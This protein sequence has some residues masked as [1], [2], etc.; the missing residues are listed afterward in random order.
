MRPDAVCGF[1]IGNP[2][3]LSLVIAVYAAISKELGLPLRFPGK[4]GAY[5][6]LAQVTDSTHL[7]RATGW[8]ATI[9]NGANKIFNITNGDYFRWEHLFPKFAKFFNM[10][11]AP[12]QTVSLAELMVD[13]EPV[14]NAIAAK[15]Q[16]KP[17]SYESL[18]TWRFGDFIFGCDY[19]VISDTTK[20]RQF[21]FHEV[22]DSETMFLNLFRQFQRVQVIPQR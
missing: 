18:A 16:L 13:K 7:A 6:A 19:D 17:Y 14:W 9:P 21:G 20:V 2:M 3:N 12:P 15:Y 10:E 22:I 8:A 1:S 4:S 5:T 11:Y